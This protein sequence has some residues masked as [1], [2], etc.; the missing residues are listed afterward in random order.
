M[1]ANAL[2]IMFEFA[3]DV[4]P[5]S[6]KSRVGFW[7]V[8]DSSLILELLNLTILLKTFSFYLYFTSNFITYIFF[9]KSFF[10]SS[11]RPTISL[12]PSARF[13][14]KILLLRHLWI[15][16]LNMMTAQFYEFL[17]KWWGISIIGTN[18]HYASTL[19]TRHSVRP[20]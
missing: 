16:F 1:N 12:Q 5:P 17:W 2:Q 7:F 6:R 8:S 15:Y 18:R 20:N 9:I 10:L 13:E 11:Q 4:L 14:W 3:R 19:L